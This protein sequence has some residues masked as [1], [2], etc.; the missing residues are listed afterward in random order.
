[1]DAVA[2]EPL[3]FKE[4]CAKESGNFPWWSLFGMPLRAK[5]LSQVIEALLVMKHI[6]I[7]VGDLGDEE[8]AAFPIHLARTL[9]DKLAEFPFELLK[10]N[11]IFDK[12]DPGFQ[13]GIFRTGLLQK[14]E[15]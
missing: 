8:G 3:V 1:M 9:S 15:G 2:G 6:K 12:G 10:A 11:F 14:R 5:F 4:E 13:G 7:R